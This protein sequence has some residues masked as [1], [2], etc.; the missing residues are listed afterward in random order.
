MCV[1]NKMIFASI[2]NVRVPNHKS[3]CR[4]HTRKKVIA[5]VSRSE[6]ACKRT[7]E[8]SVPFC[9]RGGM[10]EHMTDFSAKKNR[11]GAKS[12]PT[13]SCLAESNCRPLPYQGSALPSELR[14]QN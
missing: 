5:T 14:Q 12:I 4:R 11:N 10:T 3:M 6:R 9:E 7:D 2:M 8:P 13:W 1:I